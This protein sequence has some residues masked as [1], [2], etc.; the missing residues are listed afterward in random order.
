M[1]K[2]KRTKKALALL[3]S[4]SLIT[5]MI[6][7]TAWSAF[8]AEAN[9]TEHLFFATDRHTNTSVIGNVINNMENVIGENELDYLGLG[10]DMVGSGNSHPSYNSST[11]LGEVT[12][13]TTSLNANNVDIVAGIHD[14]NVTDDAGIVLPYKN[15]GAQIYEGN[16][17]YVYGVEEYCI[18]DD[19]NESNWSAQA[20]A[21]V[22]WAN[23][24]DVDKSK[25][26]FVLS[27]YPLH[28]NRNDNDGAMYWHKALNTV[29]TGTESGTTVVR[30][31]AFFHGHNHTV[32]SN[33]YVYNVG[34]TM[35][36]QDGS[37]KTSATIRYTYATA[38]YL[39]QNKKAT[40]VTIDSDSIEFAKYTTSGSGTAMTSVERVSQAATVTEIEVST[41]PAKT[42]Y[43]VGDTLDTTGMVVTATYSDGTTETVTDY[44]VSDVDMT[45]A[46]TKTV[47]VTYEGKTTEFTITVAETVNKVTA[48]D[49]GVLFSAESLGLTDIQI[50]NVVD[51][52]D[53]SDKLSDYIAYD[54][55]LEGYHEGE[56]V[57]YVVALPEG[58]T[59]TNLK[60][61]FIAEDG[62]E[63]ELEYTPGVDDDGFA[64][65]NFSTAYDGTFAAGYEVCN[66]PSDAVLMNFEITGNPATVKY[67]ITENS[68]EVL[69][70]NIVDLVA[71]A[72]YESESGE[73]SKEIPWNEFGKIED[74]YA[75][76]FDMTKLGTQD[77][78]LSYT[79]GDK[80]LTDTYEIEIFNKMLTDTATNVTVEMSVP[81]VT[82]VNVADN[83][84][85]EVVTNAMREYATAYVSYDI[86][87][88]GH[89]KGES[90]TVTLPIPEGYKNP[91]AYYV[92]DS[93][94]TVKNMD[95][96]VNEDGTLSFVTTHFSTYVVADG[97]TIETESGNATVEGTEDVTTT[98]KVA[99]EVKVYKLVAT[100]VSGKQYL[101]V[102]SNN[103]TG[104]GLDGDT[105]GYATTAFTGG[106]NYYSTW[107]DTSKTGTAFTTGNDVF[108]T[109]SGA[110]L[111]TA[112]SNSFSI[113]YAQSGYIG[114]ITNTLD[115]DGT[116]GTWTFS[117]S[118][119]KIN[120]KS[121]AAVFGSDTYSDY[122]LSNSGNTWSMT[123][124]SGSNVYF[125]EPVTIYKVTEKEV[126]IP[127]EPGHTYSV[128]GTDVTNAMAIA[129]LEV[130][131]GST[132]YDTPEGGTLTDITASSG[133]EPKYEVVKSKGNPG[134]I[135]SIDGAKAVLSGTA[136]TAVVKVT[137]TSGDLVAW[138]EFIV[139]T[140]I[141]DHYAIQL[142]K[143]E[144]TAVNITEFK[145]STTYYTYNEKTNTY[146]VAESYVEGTN[147]FTLPVVQ[148]DVITEPVALKGVEAG[149]TYSVW[150]V[151][152][153]FVDADDTEG[154]ELGTLGDA[155]TW[156]VSDESIAEIDKDTGVITFTGDNYGTFTVTV[157]YEGADGEVIT[158]EITISVTDSLYVVPGDGTNDFPEYPNEG[159]VRFDKTATA[160]GNFSETGIAQ[161][162]LSMTG[163]PYTTGSEI[164][165]AVMLDITGS[166]DDNANRIPATKAA[167]IAFLESIVTNEDGS[168]NDNRIGIY[169]FNKDGAG[170]VYDFGT[171]DSET[172]LNAAK[173]AINAY[174]DKQASGGTPY[175]DGLAKCQEVL[176]AAKTDGIGNNRQQFTVFMT[177]GVPTDYEYVNGTSHANYS[178]AS[179]IAG[180]LTSASDYATRDTDYKYE[181]YS[182][183]MK[184][185]GVT[186]YTVGI[187]LENKNSAWSSGTATQCLNLASALLN[188]ISG[189][190]N[191]T[192]Q[193]DAIGTSTLSKKDTYFFSVEDATAATDMKNV[194]ENI[195]LSI[196]EAATDIVVEDK[197][198]KDYS[199]NFKLP[200]NVTTDE[201]DGLSEFYIQVVDYV[202]NENKERTDEYTV[203]ENFTFNADGTFK[204]H[205]VDGV[206]CSDCSH[207][208]MKDG[209]VTAIDGTYFDYKFDSTGEY[210]TWKEEKIA[211][212]ELAL[213]Y[214]AHLDNSSDAVGTDHEIPAGTYYTN[215]YATLTYTNYN[216]VEV[217]QEFPVPQMTWN[218]AQVSYVFYLVND[219][220]QPV[221]RAGRVVPFAEAVYVTDVNTYSVI[222]NDLEQAAGLE[223]DYLA[224]QI[225]PDVYELYDDD[226]SYN[227]HVY[228]KENEVNLNNHFVIDGDV[229]D[230]YNTTTHSWTNANTTYVFNNKSDS[231]KYNT[232][233]AY[234]ANDGNDKTDS[235]TYLCKGEGTVTATISEATNVTAANF[236]DKAYFVK[237]NE[238]YV[239]AA[240]YSD[241]TT[242]YEISAASYNAAS[243]ETQAPASSMTS[244]SGGTIINGYVYYIDENGEV[245]TIVTKANGTE[246]REGFDFHNTTV[247]FAVVWKPQLEPDTVVVDYGLDAVV[248]VIANDA[249]AAGVT[250]VMTTAPNVADDGSYETA[251][252]EDNV[253]GG[254]GLW[255]A[256]VE[257]M[258]EV[259]FTQNEIGLNAPE[260]FYYEAGVNYYVGD[261]LKNTNMYSSVTVIPATTIYYEDNFV[262]FKVYDKVDGVWTNTTSD[263]IKWATEGTAQNK[264]QATDRPGERKAVMNA[265]YDADNVYGYDGAYDNMSTYSMGSAR[266]LTVDANRYGTAEFEFWGTGFDVIALTSNETGTITVQVDNI[267][268]SE[269]VKTFIVDTYYGYKKNSEGEWVV[270]NNADNTLYQVPVIETELGTYGHYKVTIKAAYNTFFDHVEGSNNYD[271]Y[272]D[273]IRIY[274]P[275]NDGAS[276]D[277]VKNAYIADGEG[278]PVYTE[279]RDNLIAADEF[280]GSYGDDPDTEADES[281]KAVEG[282]VFID[283]ASAV[284]DANIADYKN[285]GP[286]NEVYLAPGQAIAFALDGITDNVADVQ[287]GLK[288][289][290]GNAT[291]KIYN[292]ADTSLT[293]AK[294]K[295]L[296]TATGMYYSIVDLK[297]GIV[298][299]SNTG[300]SGT[301]SVTDVKVTH[302]A[303]PAGVDETGVG[304]RM[305]RAAVQT[306]LASFVPEVPETPEVPNTPVVPEQPE[307]PVV[308]DTPVTPE[309]PE[310]PS[311]PDVDKPEVNEPET[312]KAAPAKVTS[313]KTDKKT[314][315]QGDKVKVTVTTND[316][317]TKVKVGTKT[318]KTF[319][320]I[321]G[322]KT[323]T[324]TVK[325]S[326]IGKLSIS[327]TAYNKDGEASKKKTK[328]VTVK[329]FIPKT[330]KVTLSKSKVKKGAKYTVTVKTSKDVKYVKV[331]GKKITKYTYNK[332]NAT[333][334]FKVTYKATKVGKK[335]V[336]VYSYNKAGYASKVKSK[337]VTVKRK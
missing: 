212:T 318:L 312:E 210:L 32:D 150:A 148:G 205:T 197:I 265:L 316:E 94:K 65:V 51:K 275:A 156:T 152:K 272:I 146:Q 66:I 262:D 209:V 95:A 30:D 201:A 145:D 26:I 313:I 59:T 15:G 322:K 226:A 266:M 220:G 181:Y 108:L 288:S 91:I 105:T 114:N 158:D 299:I 334:T 219:A 141:P 118:Q 255:S 193:P 151:V 256:N 7:G 305:S 302:K 153:A 271:M 129:N 169:Y 243:G 70:L 140:K 39:N 10:G 89:E 217:Q 199:M 237:E 328:T 25:A 136:G 239:L 115:P 325:A 200:T 72:T 198:G 182:T 333:K 248:D 287:I 208:T 314:Y 327:A 251:V 144:L 222:W 48:E 33:E 13:A 176:A 64:T 12:G 35:S 283:G 281:I 227:I 163:V 69:P 177:D 310:T 82:A 326:K 42:E 5:G 149:D 162:E 168:Y 1:K 125:Y 223:A 228:E 143:A 184:K 187:G 9:T 260:T 211:T 203:K 58:M 336:N 304:F 180:M 277:V 189:P 131:L 232:L 134:V 107:D 329:K 241:N 233:G 285:Y 27:H 52:V 218:G 60:L 79:Y 142:H 295:A 99:E 86:S 174:D 137:Y 36:I 123:T 188:D 191:E 291:A 113:G 221:N 264:T 161:V 74:G 202:L 252:G 50:E 242:Y 300:E 195:A 278:W 245:Y 117:E 4:L 76:G 320:T 263:S 20:E 166:M 92:S 120:L 130:A 41:L 139:T 155:L 178:S 167:A 214:F 297:D 112:G 249:M 306:V 290:G 294:E 246:V 309:E 38:G 192:T 43:A 259:R 16:N 172:E 315:T 6:P 293:K 49:A 250:G 14:M 77:V 296:S 98:T 311:E 133:L 332:K 23:G 164:D 71:T 190:A 100:P 307:T 274:D 286:N 127:G 303:N 173:T 2:F 230:E 61:Y 254:N 170:T 231:I 102:N 157:A 37:S 106:N 337:T 324:T 96:I 215:E 87:L 183:E 47:T 159:A 119:L 55:T 45:T 75:L 206:T 44:T 185:A 101:I 109:T 261:T 17:F 269:N 84:D 138:D 323:W 238:K 229:T 83:T 257:N 57:E 54:V 29:A 104:Y 292:A 317:A 273:A 319:K 216:G 268:T 253:V 8:A 85:D 132:L 21:F 88:E 267:E 225:V 175:D 56:Q 240:I 331:N 81:G 111:W 279:V 321:K 301:V 18:S 103:G 204:S 196:K 34:D 78:V 11:V 165:V 244:T 46:G 126:I 224:E 258:N 236:A 270:D 110:Y 276:S 62:T 22:T 63:T 93:G 97:V 234:I 116:K 179:S 280:S 68:T 194:F 282:V 289:V 19:S 308:P 121:Y 53:L 207:V 154:T 80:T 213:Q 122:Y 298:V 73:V 147:Y 235:T 40:L 3:L 31:V 90:V 135:K 128:V 284:G 186:V 330:F 124:D 160:V 28:A 247:A 24:D 335:K 67:F 171:I